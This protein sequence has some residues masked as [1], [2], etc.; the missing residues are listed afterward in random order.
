MMRRTAPASP[1]WP[2]PRRARRRAGARD[3]AA[4]HG[5]RRARSPASTCAS[6]TSATTP[7]DKVEVQMPDGFASASYEPVAGL[8]GRGHH[9]AAGQPDPDRRRRDHRGR[10]ADHVDG[11]QRRGRHPARR[12]P[13]LRPLVPGPRQGRRQARVQ[14]AADLHR[15]R[16]RALDRRRGLRQP[17]RDR[18]RRRAAGRR[19]GV[20]RRRRRRAEDAT[21][22]ATTTSAAATDDDSG[23]GLAIVALIVGA[24]G[25]V[26]GVA[27]LLAARRASGR[28]GAAA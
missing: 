13:G 26:A 10:R 2:R 6:R 24:L 15:R 14:G 27:G 7:H 11:R 28:S 5:A 18:H 4:Q 17:G 22:A 9:R 19:R 21:P 8:D 20:A 16:G 1:R 25:L 23:N 3:A 12:V